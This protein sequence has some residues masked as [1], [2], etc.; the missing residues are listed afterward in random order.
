M[1][2]LGFSQSGS[3]ALASAL[4]QRDPVLGVILCSSY[5]V[6]HR[7][8]K[9]ALQTSKIVFIHSKNDHVV[10]FEWGEQSYHAARQIAANVRLVVVKSGGSHAVESDELVAELENL[11]S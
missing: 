3:L 1:V 5:V 6:R 8:S 11:L 10:P 4:E 7:L 9:R 2:V